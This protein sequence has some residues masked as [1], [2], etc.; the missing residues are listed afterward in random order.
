MLIQTRWLLPLLFFLTIQANAYPAQNADTTISI[1]AIGG[2]QFDV[3]RFKIKPGTK[4]KIVFANKDDMSHNLLIVKPGSR[5]AVVKAALGLANEGQR[6]NYIPELSEV[7]WA[8]PVLEPGETKTIS[9]TAPKTAGIYPYVC[10]Y[11]GHGSIMYGAIY[12]TN[13]DMPPLNDDPNIPPNR[14]TATS[15]TNGAHQNHTA[16]RS[17]PYREEP[18]FVCRIFLPDASPAAIAVS[19]PRNLSYCWDAGSCRLRYAWHGGFLD[20]TDIWKGHHDAYGLILGT[21]F[22][23]DKTAYPLQVDKPGNIP[24]VDFKGYQLINRYPEFHYTV[25]G[26]DVYELIKPKE[27]ATGLIRTFRIPKTDR[28]IWFVTDPEDG[29]HYQCAEGEW[30]NGN[31]RILPE[32]ASRFTIIMTKNKP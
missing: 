12:V 17:R 2:L 13:G 1:N 6:L 3:V 30:I 23:R 20:N 32:Q 11:P 26:I 18:P 4:V 5:T 21:V 27:D 14:K 10:T 28:T 24:V 29:V 31:L 19:L 7:L 16:A 15:K 22:F 8:V 25:N 9:F